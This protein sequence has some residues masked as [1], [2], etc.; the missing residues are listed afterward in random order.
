MRGRV[1]VPLL[2]RLD[3][4]GR[5]SSFGSEIGIGSGMMSG[6]G[7]ALLVSTTGCAG[8]DLLEELDEMTWKVAPP[9]DANGGRGP[10]GDVGD[11]GP[12]VG[13]REAEV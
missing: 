10:R 11:I 1:G 7:I 6:S 9:L 5:G 2:S 12:A 8:I 13:A 3:V 4:L